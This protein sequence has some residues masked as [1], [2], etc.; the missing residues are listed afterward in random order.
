MSGIYV[1]YVV[2]ELA[3]M[4]AQRDHHRRACTTPCTV[5]DRNNCNVSFSTYHAWVSLVP[6]S[7]VRTFEANSHV[8]TAHCL[9]MSYAA[10]FTDPTAEC[11]RIVGTLCIQILQR[12]VTQHAL[13]HQTETEGSRFSPA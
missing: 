4:Y 12:T 3:C 9:L 2:G 6:L 5:A 11:H 1:Y 10:S 7:F 8:R 13:R